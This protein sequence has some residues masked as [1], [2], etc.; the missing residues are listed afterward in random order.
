MLFVLNLSYQNTLREHHQKKLSPIHYQKKSPR[1][2]CTLDRE[3]VPPT[4]KYVRQ[5]NIV[6]QLFSKY[7]SEMM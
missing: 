5:M 3:E 1:T 7:S 4:L 6:Y 2:V